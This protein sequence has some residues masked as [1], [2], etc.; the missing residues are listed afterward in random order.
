MSTPRP[1]QLHVYS[2][3]MMNSARWEGFEP[4]ADDIL[5]C[6]SY[7]A[8][9]TWMQMICA[10]LVF[11][12]PELHRSLTEISPWLDVLTA[13]IDGVLGTYR[14]Q[15]HRRF[16]KTHTPLDGLPWFEDVV[17]L[18]CG[19][20]PRD[21]FMSMVN[22]IRNTDMEQLQSLQ[23]EQGLEPL[24]L[25]EMPDDPNDLFKVW[26]TT[27]RFE[28]EKD[29]FPFWSHFHHADTFWEFR[30]LPNLHFVHYSDL[31]ADLAGQ[32]RRIAELLEIEVDESRWPELVEAATFDAM[33]ENADQLAPE[34][35]HSIWH[36]NRQFFNKGKTGQWR[37]ALS[38]ESLSLYEEVKV[39]RVSPALAEWLE[40]G[41]LA[42][43][44]P[45]TL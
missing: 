11:Q 25:P 34:A 17:Y 3:P 15:T 45:K 12:K 44:D 24:E 31:Q 16:V 21:V 40:R 32:M 26:L 27:P 23:R 42:T 13:P 38:E 37:G 43:G 29:G 35:D 20:D 19:R 2:S 22:H 5:V 30:T 6:T 14:A 28:W 1:K 41:T 39:D 18:Y 8:G 4:R 9:T 10:L 36:D 33:K 7:K